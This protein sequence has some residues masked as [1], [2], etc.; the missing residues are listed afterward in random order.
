MPLKNAI[1]PL[2]VAERAQLQANFQQM[3]TEFCSGGTTPR[4]E[5]QSPKPAPKLSVLKRIFRRWW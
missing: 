2:S 3:L 1:Q 4:D 5:L